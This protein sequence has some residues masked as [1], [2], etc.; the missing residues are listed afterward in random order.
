MWAMDKNYRHINK[1]IHYFCLMHPIQSF[2]GVA[3]TCSS[4]E[5]MWFECEVNEERYKVEDN[6]KIT[7]RAINGGAYEH[8]YQDDFLSLMYEGFIIPKRS[9]ETHIEYVSFDEFIPGT[10]A[11]IHHEGQCIV[12]PDDPIEVG[13]IVRIRSFHF[14]CEVADVNN[15]TSEA[16]V[17]WKDDE[18]NEHTETLYLYELMKV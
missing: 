7:L 18:D 4:D 15:K 12:G 14:I 1:D 8:Y 9:D 11:Y 6:Y 10:I 2:M 5:P 16:T 3:F 17:A 13:D